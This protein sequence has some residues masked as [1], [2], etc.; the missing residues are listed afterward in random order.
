MTAFTLPDTTTCLPSGPVTVSPG[1]VEQ[2]ERLLAAGPRALLRH[3]LDD[4][5]SEAGHLA[6]YR[7]VTGM[8]SG[9]EPDGT[10]IVTAV[11]AERDR[12][13]PGLTALVTAGD[14]VRAALLRA[15]A[16]LSL[17]AG[18]WL[19]TV[20]QPATEPATIVAT[21][22]QQRFRLAGEG[23]P[24][25][26]LARLRRRA[27]LDAGVDLPDISAHA[28]LDVAG[29]APATVL[30]LVFRLALSRFPASFL[31]EVVG[32]H[33]ADFTLGIDDTL[34]GT[35]PMIDVH[36]VLREYL[37]LADRSGDGP[38]VRLRLARAVRLV[39]RLEA[40]Q[41]TLLTGI[42]QDLG[43]ATVADDLAAIIRRHMPYA[44]V[45][46]RDV[47]VG[48]RSLE[49]AF[50]GPD[51][52]L[53]AL[54]T[55]LAASRYVRSRGDAECRLLRAIRFGGPMFGILDDHEAAVLRAWTESVPAGDEPSPRP[56]DTAAESDG[57][58]WADIVGA[59]PAASTC[60]DDR[61]LNDRE[62]FHRL[63]NA[64]RWPS[65]RGAA[66]D[67]AERVFAEAEALF[68]HGSRGRYTDASLFTYTPEALV[69]RVESIYFDKLLAPYR[70]LTEIPDRDT[71]IAERKGSLLTNLVDGSWLH[72]IGSTA[73]A[74]RRSDAMLL[75]I[76]ADEMG[77]GD[78]TKNHVV[79]I[80]KVLGSLGIG[81]P[82]IREEAFLGQDELPTTGYRQPIHQLALALFPDSYYDEILGYNLAMEMWGLGELCM[83]EIQRMRRHGLDVTYEEAHLS[84][85]NMSA[86]HARQA[87]DLIIAYLDDVRRTGNDAG[88]V[89][90]HWRRIWRGYAS[91]AWF[92]ET[93]LVADLRAAH[94]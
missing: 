76:Y 9:A 93:D 13:R 75:A 45:Q 54:L 94:G 43:R 57:P 82:H 90:A 10:D 60:D 23:N 78:T 19:D 89:A 71:V 21:L 87:A 46:H 31:P 39:L 91:F 56:R 15:R 22:F 34:H 51:A 84:I 26:G 16:P 88:A 44:G 79:I 35:D 77:R 63:V 69:R 33:Y 41:H 67:R 24:H 6:A 58:S 83:H 32:V 81:L 20:S 40:G 37:A 14:R 7:V 50:A 48:G 18:C 59:G 28:F 70:P 12:I 25:H 36:E 42:G 3:L 80:H 86:G 92:V 68:E 5:E 72:T 38:R 4:L 29:A 64:E 61:S 1:T 66:R 74:G 11:T 73:R 17:T 55:D 49:D 52:D 53:A 27:L 8:L 85:D 65:V 62:L 47:H 30:P 2:A